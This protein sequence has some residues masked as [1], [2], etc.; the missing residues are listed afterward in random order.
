MKHMTEFTERL[1]QRHRSG[2]EVLGL[3]E[4]SPRHDLEVQQ[5]GRRKPTPRE[6]ARD[7]RKRETP[8]ERGRRREG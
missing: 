8:R 2:D 4:G 3:L 6:E 5:S 1:K 7:G